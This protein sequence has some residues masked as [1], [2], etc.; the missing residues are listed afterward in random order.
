VWPARVT[1]TAPHDQRAAVFAGFRFALDTFEIIA[2]YDDEAINNTICFL[3][4]EGRGWLRRVIRGPMV[5]HRAAQVRVI[6]AEARVKDAMGIGPHGPVSERFMRHHYGASGFVEKGGKEEGNMTV[7]IEA[8]KTHVAGCSVCS[9][10][11]RRVRD[12][13]DAGRVMFYHWVT[14]HPPSHIEQAE[15][16]KADYERVLEGITH[17]PRNAEIFSDS[18]SVVRLWKV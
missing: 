17:L 6:R 14:E 11:N 2:H 15:L 4:V 9:A 1:A 3:T 13:C 8:I 16:S 7:E 5:S 18:V 10:A 12:F